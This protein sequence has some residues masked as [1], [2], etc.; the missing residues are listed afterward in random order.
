MVERCRKRMLRREAPGRCPPGRGQPMG[1]M[2]W[3]EAGPPKTFADIS[4]SGLPR[5][6]TPSLPHSSV[7][8]TTFPLLFF[9]LF[10]LWVMWPCPSWD[11]LEIKRAINNYA[12]TADENWDCLK[13][14]GVVSQSLEERRGGCGEKGFSFIIRLS[15]SPKQEDFV[16]HQPLELEHPPNLSLACS[17]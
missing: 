13:H 9:L 4:G 17:P 12:R 6:K 1:A 8:E 14:M 10:V 16:Y 15:L 5:R 3:R 2:K 11:T 7:M